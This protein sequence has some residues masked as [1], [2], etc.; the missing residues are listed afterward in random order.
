[1]RLVQAIREA[2]T[3]TGAARLLSV[4]HSSAFRRLSAVEERL[5]VSLFERSRQGYSPTQAGEM[6]IAAVQ[7]ILADIT[8]LERRLEGED[9]RP[10]GVVR[11]TTTDTLLD[12]LGPVLLD[13]RANHPTII[14]ELIVANSF[15]SLMGREADIALRPAKAAPEELTGRRL[16]KVAT[17]LYASRK[18]AGQR[19]A[20]SLRDCNWIGFESS[21]SHLRSAQW[22]SANI[23]AD[24]VVFKTDS[25]LS[26]RST[27]IAGLG[28]AA[29]PC[30]LGDRTTELCRIG[31][32]LPEME[33]SLWLLTHPDLRKKARIRAVLDFIA[34]SISPQRRLI[35]GLEPL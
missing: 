5:G 7:R 14:V 34:A 22:I 32:P 20:V 31:P 9:S 11:L 2:G 13:L 21:L 19:G 24:R 17:A 29:L 26:I 33:G 6:M 16:A 1:M 4:E 28:V 15:L 10:S 27:T 8:D 23:P 35:E 25:L 30:Y 18:I 12:I 3:L